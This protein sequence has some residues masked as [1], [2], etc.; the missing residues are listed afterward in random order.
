MAPPT[1]PRAPPSGPRG[2]GRGAANSRT[3]RTSTGTSRGTAGG[4]ISKRTRPARTDR[5]GDLDLM[6]APSSARPAAGSHSTSN[7]SS[8]RGERPTGSRTS[9]R[10]QRNLDRHLGGDTSQIPRGPSGPRPPVSNTTL[11]VAG[12]KT[13]KAAT[14]SDGGIKRLVDFME[15]KATHIK[16]KDART[17][18]VRGPVRPVYI[19]KVCQGIQTKGT[20]GYAAAP[21]APDR[22]LAIFP[23]TSKIHVAWR[24]RID[25]IR[26]SLKVPDLANTDIVTQRW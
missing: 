19:K 13:S 22:H 23:R 9:S 25:V 1:G 16:N 18:G 17:N 2:G 3:S 20:E 21:M 26:S 14:N 6:S 4:G 24:R 15:K 10:L 5:D 8:R 12:L 11:S 7:P